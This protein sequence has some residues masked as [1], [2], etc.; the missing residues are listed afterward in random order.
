MTGF[1]LDVTKT[2]IVV[3]SIIQGV[4]LGLLFVPISTGRVCHVA[5]P[6]AHGRDR[7]H[8]AGAQYRLVDRHFDGDRQSDQQDD[9]MH[10]RLTEQVTPFNNALQMPDVAGNLNVQTDT[11]RAL[12]DAIVTQQAAHDRLSQRLQAA[13]D[14]DAGVI[15]LGA[16]RRHA[17][18]RHPERKPNPQRSTE[19]YFGKI[20]GASLRCARRA[21]G[22]GRRR[23]PAGAQR[24]PAPA[25]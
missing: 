25:C 17:R 14:P 23:A 15:P 5:R 1:S 4:G 12:L 21:P 22:S 19:R 18:G 20:P 9:E 7:D 16:D 13:D 24:R 3:T 10:A 6:P 8:D 2:T 11:G